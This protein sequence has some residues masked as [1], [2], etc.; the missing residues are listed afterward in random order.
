MKGIFAHGSKLFQ[1]WEKA[2]EIFVAVEKDM[3]IIIQES[4]TTPM[5]LIILNKTEKFC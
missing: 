3:T 2:R 1:I 4:D 5:L